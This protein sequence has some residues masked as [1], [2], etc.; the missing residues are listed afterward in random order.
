MKWLLAS[1]LLLIPSPA[2]ALVASWTSPAFT[3]DP[4]ICGS[5]YT[6]VCAADSPETALLTEFPYWKYMLDGTNGV[7]IAQGTWNGFVM[8]TT[9]DHCGGT[10]RDEQEFTNGTWADGTVYESV[11]PTDTGYGIYKQFWTDDGTPQGNTYGDN[12]YRLRP[13]TGLTP[14]IPMMKTLQTW[15]ELVPGTLMLSIAVGRMG[16]HPTIGWFG[17]CS[18]HVEGGNPAAPTKNGCCLNARTTGQYE[19]TS[20]SPKPAWDTGGASDTLVK[21]VYGGEGTLS[22]CNAAGLTYLG[23]VWVDSSYVPQ[24]GT[25][26]FYPNQVGDS[27]GSTPN[28]IPR[29]HMEVRSDSAPIPDPVHANSRHSQGECWYAGS[30]SENGYVNWEVPTNWTPHR[31]ACWTSVQGVGGVQSGSAAGFSRYAGDSGSATFAYIADRGWVFVGNGDDVM[32]STMHTAHERTEWYNY[33]Y[34]ITSGSCRETQ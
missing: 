12:V 15:D 25:W 16:A 7:M 24:W 6:E 32:R 33:I 17:E 5:T 31:V 26:R 30:K 27:K 1:L 29:L 28:N 22:T 20:L 18:D 4:A 11:N 8:A 2:L 3:A 19:P 34:G 23:P 9:C 13:T 21:T 10:G 14:N